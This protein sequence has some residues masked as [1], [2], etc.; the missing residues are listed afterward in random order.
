VRDVRERRYGAYER[1]V[2]VNERGMIGEGEVGD[3]KEEEDR[4]VGRKARNE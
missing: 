2:K 1:E 3:R 4:G